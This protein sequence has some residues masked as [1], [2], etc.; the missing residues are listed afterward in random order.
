M[1][2]L[3]LPFTNQPDDNLKKRLIRIYQTDGTTS[4]RERV[5]LELECAEYLH[6]TS[7]FNRRLVSYQ[8]NKKRSLHRWIK[9]KEGFS[10]KLVKLLLEDF[11]ISENDTILD[12]FA[13]SA[14]TLLVAQENDIHATGIEMLPVGQLI[15][16]A[17]TQYQ[18]YDP[19]FLDDLSQWIKETPPGESQQTYPHIPIT[20]TAFPRINEKQLL[21]YREQ[22]TSRT[23]TLHR[24]LLELILMSILEDISYTRK[25]GQYLRWDSRSTKVKER[26]T[27]RINRGKKPSK[28]FHKPQ[29]LSPKEAIMQNLNQVIQ[30]IKLLQ[31][32][33]RRYTSQ[34][35]IHSTVLR[36]LP[37][38]SDNTFAGVITS[39]PY[40]NRYDYTRTYALELTFLGLT[41]KDVLDLRQEQLS[42]TVEN[43]SKRD[44]LKAFY[45][46]TDRLTDFEHIIQVIDECAALQEIIKALQTRQETGQLNN[47]GILRMVTGY[48]TEMAFVIYEL[49]RVCRPGAFIVMVND[50]VRYSG[51]IIPVDLLT[52]Y[53]ACEFG[54]TPDTIHVLP[55]RKGNSS[56]Q[57]GRYGR[58]ALRKSITVWKK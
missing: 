55:Q 36:E 51:E 5:K 41:E 49:A 52:T 28:T 58:E 11:H 3:K 33:Q 54:L 6:T 19:T 1:S 27:K 53:F 25:D 23:D 31:S 12:P 13:G 9:F 18:E 35:L 15:W 45:E 50:N 17:K 56:Q 43:Q 40:C 32:R 37:R 29:I 48:F 47:R 10:A 38:I 42:C 14:T 24:P 4:I 30:D 2:Q 44:N 39:P 21:W 16:R 7:R 8:A 22:F 34:K 20:A 57:M 46:S 26:N